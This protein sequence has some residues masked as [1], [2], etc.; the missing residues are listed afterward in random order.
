MAAGT[1]R[2]RLREGFVNHLYM[3]IIFHSGP[4]K[5][6]LPLEVLLDVRESA[7]GGNTTYRGVSSE[8]EAAP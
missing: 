5:W 6:S 3:S 2:G 4:R 7:I 8:S 1:G